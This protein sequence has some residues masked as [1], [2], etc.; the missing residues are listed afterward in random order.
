M[1][2]YHLQC[3]AEPFF[4]KFSLDFKLCFIK[5][6]TVLED[7]EVVRTVGPIFLPLSLVHPWKTYTLSFSFILLLIENNIENMIFPE[8]T[9][10]I[11]QSTI[12]GKNVVHF[13]LPPFF[14]VFLVFIIPKRDMVKIFY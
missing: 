7:G 3:I 9:C 8:Q 11:Q 4:A 1:G 6:S 5:M 14:R 13:D 2:H 12:Q 10:N